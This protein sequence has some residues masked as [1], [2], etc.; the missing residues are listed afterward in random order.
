[1][2]EGPETVDAPTPAPAVV[3]EATLEPQRLQV[4]PWVQLVG[5]PVAL[6][7]GYLFV[8]AA[9]HAVVVFLIAGLI[10]LLLAPVVRR[11]VT[12]GIPRLL[13]VVIVF[14]GFVSIAAIITISAVNLLVDQAGEVRSNADD[15]GNAAVSRIDDTQD[16]FDD[17]GWKVDLRDQGIRFV[18]QLETRS[19][20]LSGNA[21]DF[22][23][24]FVSEVARAAFNLVLIMVITVYMLLDAPRI[25]RL[26]ASLL[27]R[28]SGVEVLFGRLEHSLFRYVVGQTLASLVMGLS[29][30]AGMWMLG[31]TGVWD[32]GEHYAVLFG[33]VVAVT[34]FAPSIGPAIGS[35]PPILTAIFDGLGPAIA[36]ALFFLLLHQ[37]EGH[38]VIPKLMGAAIAVHPLL[39][40]FGIVAGAQVMGIGGILLALPLLAV[41]REIVLFLRERVAF[42]SWPAPEAAAVFG[43][44]PRADAAAVAASMGAPAPSDGSVPARRGTLVGW[45]RSGAARVRARRGGRPSPPT[46]TVDE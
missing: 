10:S 18:D 38:V 12:V 11:L 1:M 31:V 4:P 29:A 33:L 36:V 39:V 46:T 14:G 41:G 6:L 16:F 19:T 30:A 42:G 27:P 13:S 26:I 17:H 2:T 15:I 45:A 8:H 43:T 7:F 44:V 37:I 24:S 9:S 23:R 20:E 34:E 35:I 21:L 5:L 32:A 25:S 40:I 22:G 3:G 28:G